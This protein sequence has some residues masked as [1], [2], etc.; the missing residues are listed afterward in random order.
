[1]P[2]RWVDRM[3][4]PI[5]N[6]PLDS[7]F[8]VCKTLH[9]WKLKKCPNDHTIEIRITFV[10]RGRHLSASIHQKDKEIYSITPEDEQSIDVE[11]M[12]ILFNWIVR[13]HNKREYL[14]LAGEYLLHSNS[15]ENWMAEIKQIGNKYHHSANTDTWDYFFIVTDA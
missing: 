2:F 11:D 1:M 9:T 15:P 5:L 8:R 6:R 4:E 14:F 3:A 13:E 12:A 7:I 10:K